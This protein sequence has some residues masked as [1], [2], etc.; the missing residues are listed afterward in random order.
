MSAVYWQ[1]DGYLIINGKISEVWAAENVKLL[2]PSRSLEVF[3]RIN[4]RVLSAL[5]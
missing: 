5:K 2:F 4:Q 3:I 1:I